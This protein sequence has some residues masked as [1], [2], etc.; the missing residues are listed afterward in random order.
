[1]FY[2]SWR[3]AKAGSITSHML[4]Q[5]T[6][7]SCV[8]AQLVDLAPNK[9]GTCSIAPTTVPRHQAINIQ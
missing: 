7:L 2:R 3:G 6:G 4:K 9:P 5:W 8:H 1:M